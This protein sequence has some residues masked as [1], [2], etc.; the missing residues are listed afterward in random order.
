MISNVPKCCLLWKVYSKVPYLHKDS[1][2]QVFTSN[3][4]V[5]CFSMGLLNHSQV[6]IKVTNH[7]RQNPPSQVPSWD[8]FLFIKKIQ[9]IILFLSGSSSRTHTIK[10]K[11]KATVFKHFPSWSPTYWS[12]N[13]NYGVCVFQAPTSQLIPSW[14]PSL[15]LVMTGR[16]PQWLGVVDCDAGGELWLSV[17]WWVTG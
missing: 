2:R 12:C 8:S 10:K 17:F 13:Q 3:F 16:R 14:L 5:W 1:L 15:S 9:F 6:H 11:K 7:H 4:N